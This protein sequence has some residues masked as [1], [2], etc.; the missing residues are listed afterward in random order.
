MISW[1]GHLSVLAVVGNYCFAA[2]FVSLR[3][4]A[5]CIWPEVCDISVQFSCRPNV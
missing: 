5:S 4:S 2:I 1:P 3:P